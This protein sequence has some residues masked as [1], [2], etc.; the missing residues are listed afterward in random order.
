MR[1]IPYKIV[2][3]LRYNSL[4]HFVTCHPIVAHKLLKLNRSISSCIV[5]VEH[6]RGA[7][8]WTPGCSVN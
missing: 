6:A 8:P 2:Q 7:V 3:E 5:R 1:I 4:N